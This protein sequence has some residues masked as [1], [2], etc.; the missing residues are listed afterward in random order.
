[1]EKWTPI[2][3]IVGGGVGYLSVL[4]FFNSAKDLFKGR[5]KNRT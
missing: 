2:F 4:I 3:W 1:M 5:K